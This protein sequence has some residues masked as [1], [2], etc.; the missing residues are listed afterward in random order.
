M[1]NSLAESNTQC[2][3]NGGKRAKTDI[4][5]RS[6]TSNLQKLLITI[7]PDT[8][9]CCPSDLAGQGHH[10]ELAKWL[11]DQEKNLCLE[12]FRVMSNHDIPPWLEQGVSN[13]RHLANRSGLDDLWESGAAIKK[14]S[15]FI[16]V[17]MRWEK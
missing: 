13:A 10:D 3:M 15:A 11:V 9:N 2:G 1:K 17:N 4:M 8:E 6:Q 12:A 5:S 7:A 16:E 14:I